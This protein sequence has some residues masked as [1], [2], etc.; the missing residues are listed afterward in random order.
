MK[1]IKCGSL[2]LGATLGVSMIMSDALA[3]QS[4]IEKRAVEI[5]HKYLLTDTHI[6]VPYRLQNMPD[7]DVSGSTVRVWREV[8]AYAAQ[9]E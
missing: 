1:I 3:E 2:L 5:T 9:S 4:S 8:E 7:Q 6:D